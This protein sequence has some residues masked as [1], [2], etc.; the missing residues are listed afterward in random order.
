MLFA[1]KI[2]CFT[3]VVSERTERITLEAFVVVDL[4]VIELLKKSF[5][6]FKTNSPDLFISV[7]SFSAI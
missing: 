5:Q 7:E 6:G 3:P 2:K 4:N 1:N